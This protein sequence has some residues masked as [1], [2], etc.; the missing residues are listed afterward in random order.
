MN[1]KKWRNAV[2]ETNSLLIHSG[3]SAKADGETRKRVPVVA[4]NT[5]AIAVLS[6]GGTIAASTSLT[7]VEM[8]ILSIDVANLILAIDELIDTKLTEDFN[9]DMVNGIKT[10]PA[11]T[12]LITFGRN[13]TQTQVDNFLNLINDVLEGK[14]Q[15][16]YWNERRGSDESKDGSNETEYKPKGTT[17]GISLLLWKYQIGVIIER[18]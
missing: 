12:G 17:R 18:K 13:I 7:L 1:L 11:V 6:G 5:A 15:V 3:I 9:Q 8:A 4:K 14:D 16:D 10:S 2:D